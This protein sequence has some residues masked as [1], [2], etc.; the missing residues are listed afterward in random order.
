LLLPA[1]RRRHRCETVT[2]TSRRSC[3]AAAIEVP[4]QD[5]SVSRIPRTVPSLSLMTPGNPTP[6][7]AT[8]RSARRCAAA[9]PPSPPSRR[10]REPL[11][12]RLGPTPGRALRPAARPRLPSCP[13]SRAAVRCGAA[14]PLARQ[15]KCLQPQTPRPHLPAYWVSRRRGFVEESAG[16]CGGARAKRPSASPSHRD[17]QDGEEFD[18]RVVAIL[19]IQ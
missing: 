12:R 13:A 17:R 10:C 1:G 6:I 3:S 16:R 2:G 5:R 14:S 15:A 19:Y 4:R 9:A 18:H 11:S 8:C 7:P